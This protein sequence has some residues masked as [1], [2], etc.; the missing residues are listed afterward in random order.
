MFL[1]N[2]SFSVILLHVLSRSFIF[3]SFSIIFCHFLSFSFMFFF[4]VCRGL[5]I[6]FLGLNFA[7]ISLHISFKNNS[8]FLPVLG[9]W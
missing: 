9:E 4:S 8:I 1:Q 3:I 5:K 7:T 2:L 6:F